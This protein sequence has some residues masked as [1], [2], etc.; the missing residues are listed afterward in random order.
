MSSPPLWPLREHLIDESVLALALL[1]GAQKCRNLC[2]LFES[3]EAA[4]LSHFRSLSLVLFYHKKIASHKLVM[5]TSGNG[6][7]GL[8]LEREQNPPLK[9]SQPAQAIITSV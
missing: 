1:F 9:S 6:C 2:D 3:S 4:L 8:I 7:L 5:G